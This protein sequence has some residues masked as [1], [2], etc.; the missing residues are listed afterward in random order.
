[1]QSL[2]SEP[3]HRELEINRIP[4]SLA[5]SCTGEGFRGGWMCETCGIY[6]YVDRLAE[7]LQEALAITKAGAMDHH[8]STHA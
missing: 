1:M 5:I 4:Y 7:S 3:I 8:R 2:E 6:H